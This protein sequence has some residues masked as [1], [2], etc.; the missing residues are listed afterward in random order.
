MRITDKDA[1]V[2]PIKPVV[3]NE[4]VTLTPEQIAELNQKL[5]T[6]RHDVNGAL[7]VIVATM[8]LLRMKPQE[9]GRFLA[10]LGEQPL[11]IET[12]VKAFS[13]EFEKTLGIRRPATVP[14][15]MSQTAHLR[16][17]A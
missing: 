10:S 2:F 4:P 12:C 14:P 7:A 3:P 13:A 5:S 15:T 1:M 9:A 8:E 6:M 17:Q 16:P 11:R